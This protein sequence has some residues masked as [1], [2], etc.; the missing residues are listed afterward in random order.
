MTK[1]N[2]YLYAVGRRKRSTA[3]VRLFK[4]RGKTVVNDL[5]VEKYFKNIS[6]TLFLKPF[7]ITETGSKYYAT[8]KVEGGGRMGQMGAFVQG[9]SRALAL[10]DPEKFK[11]RLRV[12]GLLTRD[13]REKER[14]KFGLAQSARAKKQ[15]PKR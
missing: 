12:A 13:P 6:Q 10:A 2:K 4:G 15:S 7:E 14:R 1:E 11:K 5:P 8:V 3:R 9:V